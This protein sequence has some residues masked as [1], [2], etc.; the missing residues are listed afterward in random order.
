MVK[1]YLISVVKIWLKLALCLKNIKT[2]V[3]QLLGYPWV[4][5]A[6][7]F[8]LLACNLTAR[9]NISCVTQGG[10]DC[11]EIEKLLIYSS[12]SDKKC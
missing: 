1:G 4:G 9:I 5:K 12:P 8:L 7:V 11:N 2:G 3:S 6:K 10:G